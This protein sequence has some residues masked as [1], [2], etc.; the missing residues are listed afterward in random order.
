MVKFRHWLR[1]CVWAV[2]LRDFWVLNG[3]VSDLRQRCE[4]LEEAVQELNPGLNLRR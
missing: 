1:D 2:R 4:R 3:E